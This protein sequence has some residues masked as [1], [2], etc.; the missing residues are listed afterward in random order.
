MQTTPGSIATVPVPEGWQWEYN[1]QLDTV[2]LLRPNWSQVFISIYAPVNPAPLLRALL[3]QLGGPHR[4]SEVKMIRFA[5]LEGA[6]AQ[7]DQ[8]S[9][10][11]LLVL[12]RED[13]VLLLRGQTLGSFTEL[14]PVLEKVARGTEPAPATWPR[15]L[16]G[17]Y[18]AS[19]PSPNNGNGPL[20]QDYYTFHPDGHVES[21]TFARATAF[22]V[23]AAIGKYRGRGPHWEVRGNRLLIFDGRVVFTNFLVKARGNALE[24]YDQRNNK[25][26]ATRQ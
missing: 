12:G 11:W 4:V 26:V 2:V 25:I 8:P 16:V 7:V 13:V 10:D 15:N 14:M 22:G 3:Y 9:R 6:S 17:K 18:H 20:R 19:A 24:L 21:S 5:G 23:T 1:E